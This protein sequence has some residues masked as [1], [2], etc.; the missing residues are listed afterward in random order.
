MRVF[1]LTG[2]DLDPDLGEVFVC[3]DLMIE[4][5]KQPQLLAAALRTTPLT[6]SHSIPRRPSGQR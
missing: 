6:S 5:N 1:V 3:V 2:G 4:G